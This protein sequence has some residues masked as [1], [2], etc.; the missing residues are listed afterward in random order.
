VNDPPPERDRRFTVVPRQEPVAPLDDP[1]SDAADFIQELDLIY[2]RV[3][4]VIDAGRAAFFDGSPSYDSAS[5]AII[6]L[7]ALLDVK[8][9]QPF[10]GQLT[11]AERR[12]INATRVVTAHAH[13]AVMDDEEF[14]HTVTRDV[15][16]V[17]ARLRA[18][19]E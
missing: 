8:R 18:R 4:R 17:V 19:G 1:A 6:R 9:F 12:A 14:W 2:S 16:D 11:D 3:R 13:Y 7:R 5:M 15:P 10:L